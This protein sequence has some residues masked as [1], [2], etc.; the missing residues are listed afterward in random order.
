MINAMLFGVLGLAVGSF[1]HRPGADQ[2]PDVMVMLV[3]KL[4]GWAYGS[5][6]D[7]PESH[8]TIIFQMRLARVVLAVLVGRAGLI[9][10]GPAGSPAESHGGSL[11]PGHFLWGRPGGH[12]S[13]AFWSG[14]A[15]PGCFCAAPD[16]LCRRRGHC[17]YSVQCGQGGGPD[18]GVDT[19]PGRHCRG[20]LSLSRDLLFH[21]H[22]RSKHPS[23]CLLA[24]GR[25]GR[26]GLGPRFSFC[27]PTLWQAW[28]SCPE[29]PKT[30]CDAAGDEPAQHLGVDVDG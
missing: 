1:N 11:Y 4:P 19:D 24:D 18:T 9:R 28:P 20:F 27:C 3:R 13:H 8:E 22:Q 21:D 14:H 7:W 29:R 2:S 12:R 25:A 26:P 17:H 23:G 15:H 10:R 5:A 30:E 6:G 16:S